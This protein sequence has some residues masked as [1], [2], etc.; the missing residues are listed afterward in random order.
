MANKNFKQ[1]GNTGLN[2]FG[3]YV[4]EEFLPHLKHPQATKVYQEMADNDAVIG[5][6]LYISEMLIRGVDWEV[7]AAGDTPEDLANKQFLEEC[8][9][10]M[11]HSWASFITEALSM[12]TY[13]FSFHEIIYK[14]RKGPDESKP[15]YKSKYTDGKIGWRKI[16][17]RAQ[18]TI[19][20]WEFDD[21]GDIVAVIQSAPPQFER[22]RIPL[23]KG[24]LFRTRVSK[25]NPEGKSLL[26]NAYRSWFFKKRIEE[27]EAIGIDRDL[28][29]LPVLTTPEGLDIWNEED[30]VMVLYKQNA[31][32]I[33][34]NIR[35]DAQEG[36]VLPH[37]WTFEL[38]STGGTRQFDT[39]AIVNRYD[40]RIATTLLADIV[41]IGQTMSGSFALADTKDTFFSTALGSM[42]FNIS[43]VINAY[44]VQPLF[45]INNQHPKNG[46]PTVVPG[47]VKKA[48]LNE[49]ALILRAAGLDINKDYKLHS[50]VRDLCGMP[51]I[52]EAEFEEDY[53]K[54]AEEEK[55]YQRKTKEKQFNDTSDNS[56]K[57]NDVKYT[58]Q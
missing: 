43:D 57:M 53:I 2:R 1:L 17:P 8:M 13:G 20:E 36:L 54:P 32:T 40:F 14:I 45:C 3:G 30:E 25:D 52:S 55:E 7:K 26:R 46:Y 5:A 16:A 22:V 9:N 47:N 38:A 10:D 19:V 49:V 21:E 6:I 23:S 51:S 34:Q 48:K 44:A 31:E 24:L 56:L 12:F 37:G 28:A 27:I 35:R 50:Y 58:G 29:G 11:S 4:Y 33:I 41:L 18:A 42:L 39:N 15:M